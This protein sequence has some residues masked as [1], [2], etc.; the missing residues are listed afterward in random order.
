MEMKEIMLERYDEEAPNKVVRMKLGEA[1]K[2]ETKMYGQLLKIHLTSKDLLTTH[3]EH[4]RTWRV[5]KNKSV[6]V[7]FIME[8]VRNEN[9]PK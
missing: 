6:K 3:I 4:F 8:N 5:N 1:I 7:R 2:K 9:K